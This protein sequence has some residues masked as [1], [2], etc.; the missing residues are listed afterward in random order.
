MKQRLPF[1]LA[2]FFTSFLSQA[3]IT[4]TAAETE[5]M[6]TV[7]SSEADVTG[8][9]EVT[10]TAPTAK[11]YIWE[12]EIVGLPAVW[13]TQV[14]DVN[15]C[16]S[17]PV[18]SEEMTL[19]AGQKFPLI[20]HFLPKNTDGTG[21]CKIKIYEKGNPTNTLTVTF[22]VNEYI[23]STD[24]PTAEAIKMFPNPCGPSLRIENAPQSAQSVSVF[25]LRGRRVFFQAAE[26]TMLLDLTA[27]PASQYVVVVEGA[28]GRPIT[29]QPVRKSH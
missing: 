17:A 13:E 23:S 6:V 16:W 7:K 21:L 15:I 25:D 28:G 1:F 3:Q 27:L 4:L 24:N 20:I 29:A 8:K 2:F 19:D 5:I 14:C 11:T 10:N 18:G 9:T 12:R 26:P 22:N